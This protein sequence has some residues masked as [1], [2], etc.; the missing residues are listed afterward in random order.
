LQRLRREGQR[1][2]ASE[3]EERHS[4]ERR[5]V[6]REGE[7]SATRIKDK[8]ITCDEEDDSPD[9]CGLATAT[10]VRS[11][12]A[13]GPQERAESSV[14]GNRVAESKKAVNAPDED[15]GVVVE[16][17]PA[18]AATAETAR[19]AR[20]RGAAAATTLLLLLRGSGQQVPRR[21]AIGIEKAFIAAW[22][23]LFLFVFFFLSFPSRRAPSAEEEKVVGGA[24]RR[25][26]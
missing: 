5:E 8:K 25:K 17:R 15:D 7:K 6:E 2:G 16:R 14:A 18:A 23:P 1:R 9:D 24:R 13:A 20:G 12:M 21:E 11:L 22:S 4:R 10:I 26:K 19:V 3:R